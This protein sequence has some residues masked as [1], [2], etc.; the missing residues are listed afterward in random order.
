MALL[1]CPP[2][3]PSFKVETRI[4]PAD[5]KGREEKNKTPQEDLQPNRDEASKGEPAS[6]K[7]TLKV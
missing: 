6:P 5:L 3:L 7:Q 1:S 2:R 4:S